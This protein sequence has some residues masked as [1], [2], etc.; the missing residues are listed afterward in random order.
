MPDNFSSINWND[1]IAFLAIAREKSLRGAAR[2]LS[3]NHATIKRRLSMLEQSLETRLFDRSPE[4]HIL[5]PAG[6]QL[7]ISATRME[8]EIIS[9]Q[10]KITGNDNRPFGCI[11]ISVPPAMIGSFLSKELANFSRKYPDIEIDVKATHLFSDIRRGETDI[12]IRMANEVSDDVVGRR[13]IQYAKAIY[14]SKNYLKDFDAGE[15]E[16]YTWIGWG[17]DKPYH[18]WV[19]DTPF[20]DIPVKHK[21]FSNAMQIELARHGMGLALLPCFLG[22]IELDLERVP[23]TNTILTNSIWVLLH[24]DLQKTAKVRVFVDFICD[25]IKKNRRLL[26]GNLPV[27]KG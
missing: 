15:P 20:P 25:A 9:T 18:D 16:K 12:A 14:A 7:F 21:I 19:V 1:L 3:V 23:N 10:R 22:D 17:N 11:K 13:V 2:S 5:S 24:K 6:E 26:M 27:T 4:G 8:E